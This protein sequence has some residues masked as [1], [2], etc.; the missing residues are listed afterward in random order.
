MKKRNYR[1]EK[2]IKSNKKKIKVPFFLSFFAFNIYNK[3][4]NM[5]KNIKNENYDIDDQMDDHHD[6]YMTIK[7]QQ[8]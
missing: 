2:E 5:S 7:Q 8:Q 3:I 6:Y 1:R 4:N